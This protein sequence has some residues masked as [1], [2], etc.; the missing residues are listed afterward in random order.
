MVDIADLSFLN[1]NP[2]TIY[3]KIIFCAL[4]VKFQ[5][6]QCNQ[7]TFLFTLYAT[8]K[9]VRVAATFIYKSKHF[10]NKRHFDLGFEL[11]DALFPILP[12]LQSE[13]D[14]SNKISKEAPLFNPPLVI[15]LRP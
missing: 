6:L 5:Y 13:A 9:C 15:V 4:P 7:R 12:V 1:Y 8:I 2:N 10:E 3:T 11:G 14:A